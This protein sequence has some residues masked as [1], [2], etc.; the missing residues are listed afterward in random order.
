MIDESVRAPIAA[1]TN[2]ARVRCVRRL[3]GNVWVAL[4]EAWREVWRAGRGDG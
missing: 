4:G 1:V 3:G 2:A